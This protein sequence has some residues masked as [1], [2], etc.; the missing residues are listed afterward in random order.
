M[1]RVRPRNDSEMVGLVFNDTFSY[2]LKFSWGHRVPVV[3]EHF[4][5]SG[6]PLRTDCSLCCF[7]PSPMGN[8]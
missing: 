1:D 2:R 5:Y 8:A 3:R 6:K 4:E 7:V